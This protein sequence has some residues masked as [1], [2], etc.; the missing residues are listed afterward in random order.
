MFSK[1]VVAALLLIAAMAVF[2]TLREEGQEKA[3]GGVLAP[4]ET[5]RVPPSL[6]QDIRSNSTVNPTQTDYG[7]LVKRVRTKVNGAMD[8]SEDRSSRYGSADR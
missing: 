2:L 5:T 7:R 4:I 3:F 6:A 8:R 1:R